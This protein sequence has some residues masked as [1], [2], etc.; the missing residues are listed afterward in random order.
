M[1]VIRKSKDRGHANHG[2]LDARHTFSFADYY[3]P[4]HMGFRALRVI[5]EDRVAPG[6]GFD[7]HPHRDMEIITYILEGALEHKDSMGHGEQILPG[8]F[9]YMSAGSGVLHSEFNPSQKDPVHLLQI[10]IKPD[11]KGLPPRYE[12][13]KIRPTENS[14]A[15]TLIASPSGRANSIP[16]RQDMEL[17][18]ISMEPSSQLRYPLKSGRHAWIQIT[19]GELEINGEKLKVGDGASVGDETHLLFRAS[20]PSEALLFDLD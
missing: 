15:L 14:T 6:M 1:I 2:W 9:Q 4:H 19:R 10:W 16:I 11:R 20:A 3:D 18:L 12:K 13:R 5:N 7:T 17:S 8:E